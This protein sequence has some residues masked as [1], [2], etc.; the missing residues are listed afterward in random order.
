[1]H[2][3]SQSIPREKDGDSQIIRKC[4]G[5]NKKKKITLPLVL[6]VF[7]RYRQGQTSTHTGPNSKAL[8]FELAIEGG[9]KWSWAGGW[10]W[11]DADAARGKTE[12]SIGK[13]HF[14]TCSAA[15]CRVE[16]LSSER[17]FFFNVRYGFFFN[18][19]TRR[20]KHILLWKTMNNQDCQS[21]CTSPAWREKVVIRPSTRATG[22]GAP[23]WKFLWWWEG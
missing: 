8:G 15:D 1:M 3:H 12:P 17:M 9:E 23:N 16:F 14:L 22:F 20:T 10:R 5:M 19:L 7:G 6:K 21:A 11:F 13:R 2:T 18:T 4:D